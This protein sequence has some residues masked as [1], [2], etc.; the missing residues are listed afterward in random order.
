MRNML[1]T[2]ITTVRRISTELRPLILDEL[3]FQEAV[4]W[5]AKDFAKRSGL[6][7]TFNL[8]AAGLITGDEWPTAF[9]RIVQ[10]SL[11]NVARHAGATAVQI[12][13]VVIA[14]NLVLTVHDNGKGMKTAVKKDGIG[15]I[16][17]RERSN[18]IGAQFNIRS[19]IGSGTTIEVTMALNTPTGI[20]S[21]A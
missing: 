5:H 12:D 14:D 6:D 17:M 20:G 19:S 16:S 18:A 10:E 11:T 21:S 3:G 9:F 8:A 1:D 15:L 13:L 7:I 4:A 2:A